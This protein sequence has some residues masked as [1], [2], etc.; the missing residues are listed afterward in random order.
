MPSEKVKNLG[1]T[2][3]SDLSF[4]Q[5]V[6]SVV[7]SC[8]C[9]IRD[10]SRIRKYLSLKQSTAL[11]NALVSSRLDYCNSL[12]LN[13]TQKEL[14]RLQRVQNIICRIT[15]K[16]PFQ[17]SITQALRSLHWLPVK[18]RIKFKYNVLTYKALHTGHP[19]YLREY[20]KPYASSKGTRRSDPELMYLGIQ[21]FN[22]RVY[23]NKTHISKA[24][25]VAAPN[26]WNILPTHI[27]T[28]DSI[29]IFRRKLKSHLFP[30]T[31][32]P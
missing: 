24:F 32:P 10:F 15:L 17:S 1:V 25:C 21:S 3:D 27:R 30:L 16:L 9:N 23:K 4:S 19:A 2:L 29:D 5:H 22:S 12:F 18:S 6:S 13:I 20:L 14:M 31:E 8:Y 28:S 26:L 11:A 7:R